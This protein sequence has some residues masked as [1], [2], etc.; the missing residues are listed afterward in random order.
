MHDNL[1]I[2]V[3]GA[4]GFIGS[5][6]VQRLVNE[7]F[8]VGI[9]KR[10][11]SDSW[12]IKDSLSKPEVYDLDI[13]D[14]DSVHSAFADFKPDAI[15]HLATYYAVDHKSPEAQLVADTNVSGTI[16]LLEASREFA[17]RLFVNTS[18]C[19]V[20]KSSKDKLSESMELDPLNLYAQTKILA[21][22]A[23]TFYAEKYGLKS[24]T[25]RLFP[26]YGPYDH[27]RRLIPYTIKNLI[28]GKAPKMTSGEQQWDFVY[29]DDIVDAY[30]KALSLYELP[31]KHEIVNIGTGNAVSIRNIVSKI[32]EITGAELEPEW[33]AIPH[34]ANELWYTCADIDKAERILK[35]KPKIQILSEGL[36]STVEWY[37][38]ILGKD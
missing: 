19:F 7:G 34:R 3:T 23:C 9:T 38:N 20:Y 6:L 5:R 18:S 16:N 8:T 37:K 15:F 12:R 14:F 32:Q 27:E 31:I 28:E 35:W 11:N 22:Q 24:I 36:Q 13:R 10:K 1:K 4:T 30:L 33:G 21:E 29:I 25:F 2:L 26:P 17:V